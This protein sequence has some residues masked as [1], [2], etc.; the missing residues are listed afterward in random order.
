MRIDHVKGDDGWPLVAPLEGVVYPPHLLTQ[1]IWRD[2]TWAR[3]DLRILVRVSDD[4]VCHVGLYLRIARLENTPAEIVGV[5]GVMTHPE[6]R[7]RGH[8]TAAM[9]EAARVMQDRRC[10]FGLLFCEPHNERFYASLGWEIF[11]GDVYCEQPA[12][13][14]CFDMMTTMVRAVRLRPAAGTM[15]LCGLPW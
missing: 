13:R 2:V 5:G 12:G 1:V 15:D 11:E 14:T 6:E 3:A 9:Q 8:A 10:D 7:R 4:V